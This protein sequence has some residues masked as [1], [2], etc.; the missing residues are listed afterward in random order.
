MDTQ[1]KI[2]LRPMLLVLAAATLAWT[3]CD[4]GP[5]EPVGRRP[6]GILQ[7]GGANAITIEGTWRRTLVFFDDFG[8]LHSS[9]TTWTFAAGGSAERTIVTTN[10]TLEESDTTVTTGRWRLDG[11]N[12]VIEFE[13]P[14]TGTITLE[15]RV[16]GTSL[17]LAG[18]E[19][20]RVT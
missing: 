17:F 2:R 1:L 16:Q 20:L 9:E 15:V 18:Q 3:A 5:V 19:Y 4:S 8:F 12:V 6:T 10:I 7:G 13:P 11:S 14:G